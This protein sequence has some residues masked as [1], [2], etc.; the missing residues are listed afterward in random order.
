MAMYYVTFHN[1]A[2]A[3]SDGERMI[4]TGSYDPRNDFSLL[5]VYLGG[6]LISGPVTEVWLE[7]SNSDVINSE[8]II[9]QCD[10]MMYAEV[11]QMIL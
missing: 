10:Y 6:G 3:T 5:P 8:S 9:W 4:Y 7:Y 11:P 2:I 1:L